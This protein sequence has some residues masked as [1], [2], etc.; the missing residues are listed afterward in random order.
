M[1]RPPYRLSRTLTLATLLALTGATGSAADENTSRTVGGT[2]AQDRNDTVRSNETRVNTTGREIDETD[3]SKLSRGDRRFLERA[4]R[5]GLTEARLAK[6]AAGRSSDPRVRSLAQQIVTAHE[7]SNAEL[8]ELA[9]RKGMGL[10]PD[11]QEGERHFNRLSDITG[12]EF[13]RRFVEHMTDS[14]EDAVDLYEKAA[15]KS[16]DADVAA[17]ASSH[18]SALQQHHTLAQ[19]LEKTVTSR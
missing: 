7:K 16:D 14:H 1:K 10:R 12:P 9:A 15:R 17:F 5:Q 13:D 6:L 8:L 18:L 19:E 2:A 3:V 11:D 4:S